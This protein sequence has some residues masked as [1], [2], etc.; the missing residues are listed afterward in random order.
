[1]ETHTHPHSALYGKDS[2]LWR[3]SSINTT[4]GLSMLSLVSLINPFSRTKT[5]PVMIQYQNSKEWQ[6][7]GLVEEDRDKKKKR[8][9]LPS[10]MSINSKKALENDKSVNSSPHIHLIPLDSPEY[11]SKVSTL[12]SLRTIALKG[13]KPKYVRFSYKL[14][15]KTSFVTLFRKSIIGC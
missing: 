15:S 2:H 5:H 6:R 12:E 10:L 7:L 1:M 9:S 13:L 8:F 3:F 14:D 4:S 11:P